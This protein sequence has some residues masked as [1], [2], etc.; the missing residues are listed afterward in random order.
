MAMS[1]QALPA[2][3]GGQVG[4]G[5]KEISDFGFDRPSQELAGSLAKHVGQQIFEVPW[6][7]KGN[8][9]IVGHGVSLLSGRC[10]W[11]ITATIRQLLSERRHQLSRIARSPEQAAGLQNQPNRRLGDVAP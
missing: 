3:L 5:C 2:I 7:A 10:G 11:L 9:S 4:M 1:N 6:L 8:N